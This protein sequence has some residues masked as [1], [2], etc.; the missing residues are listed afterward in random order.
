MLALIPWLATAA[1]A[2]FGSYRSFMVTLVTLMATQF[3][4]KTLASFGAGWVVYELS[5]WGLNTIYSYVTAE[6]TSLPPLFLNTMALM[7]LDEALQIMFS[8]LSVRLGLMGFNN[9]FLKIFQWR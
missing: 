8:A 9:G 7:R 2:I 3:L 4:V 6:F 5:G 1:T